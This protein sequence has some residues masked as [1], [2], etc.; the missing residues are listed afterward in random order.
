VPAFVTPCGVS[1]AGASVLASMPRMVLIAVLAALVAAPAALA[2]PTRDK[3][4]RECQSGRLSGDY[5]AREIR[6]ARANIPDDVDQ[7]TDCRDVLARALL[8]L[9][10]GGGAGDGGGTAGGGFGGGSGSGTT[11][12]TGG[13]A[14]G[15]PLTPSTDADRQALEEAAASG[16]Q[17]V[18]IAGRRVTPGSAS[19]DI[20]GTLLA[21]L[22]LLAAAAA[23]ALLPYLRRHAHAPVALLRRRV[24]PGR[25]G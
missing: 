4:L 22:I 10:G 18:E 14:G 15:A 13:G 17:P 12:G 6:D 20:P 7:Y 16:G 9:A 8:N 3:I 19:N 24:L 21:L 23:A 25:S 1:N 2:N 5:T 11:G